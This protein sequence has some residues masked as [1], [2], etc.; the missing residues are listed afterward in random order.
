MEEIWIPVK[1][2][3]FEHLYDVSNF[4]RVR[5]WYK[6][7]RG[8]SLKRELP[9]IRKLQKDKD[10]YN[11]ITLYDKNIRKSYVVS[12]LILLC[13][14]GIPPTEKHQANHINNIPNDDRL[15]NLEWVTKSQNEMHKVI[16][17]T[18]NRGE[19]HPRA[20][21][22]KSKVL[23]IRHYFKIGMKTADISRVLNVSAGT[24]SGV[25]HGTSWSWLV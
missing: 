2:K 17:G 11:R 24:I 9:K 25:K 21:L 23:L 16:F 6:P 13:F 22:N 20:V 8:E 18:S 12:R 3:G 19:R 10:G 14:I 1:V 15:C 7:T 5:G 4:G